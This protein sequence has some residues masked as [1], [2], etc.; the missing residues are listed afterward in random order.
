MKTQ[1]SFF[2]KIAGIC[3]SIT[4][5]ANFSCKKPSG[6]TNN[7]RNDKPRAEFTFTYSNSGFVPAKVIFSSTSSNAT[8]LNWRFGNGTISNQTAVEVTYNDPGTY[9][10]TLVASNQYGADSITKQVTIS[11]SKP[12][13]DFTFTTTNTEVLPVVVTTTNTTTGSNVTYK[14]TYGAVSSTDAN[15]V[16]NLSTGGI[17]NIKLVATNA[18]GSDSIVKSIRIS[19]YAQSYTT[20]DR[21]PTNLFA[22]DG[23][24]VMILSRNSNL[25]RSS[26][27]KWLRAMD[28]AYKY[29]SICTG[30]EPAYFTPTFINQR[31]TIA[32][33]AATCGAA[34]GYLGATGIEIQNTYFDIVYNRVNNTNSFEHFPFYEFG[35]NFWFYDTK[36]AY[37]ANDP[38]ATGYAVFMGFMAMRAAGVTGNSSATQENIIDIYLANTAYNWSNTLALGQSVPGTGTSGPDLFSSFCFRLRRDYGGDAFVEKLWK[39]AGQRPNALT[40]Q[41]AVDNFFLA[42]CGAANKNLTTVFQSWRWPLS[43]GAITAASQYP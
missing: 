32:D 19:P 36:L 27:F 3:I 10:V 17:Y 4:L 22:W 28:S 9:N 25:N 24:K 11:L 40:T 6:E 15:P 12:I 34:C 23:S 38:V 1:L 5:I 31:S 13:A 35:R 26:M 37:K 30:R 20:F 42:S 39:M 8:T 41:D 43:A 29:Y 21:V 7:S 33:V 2:F 14:W 18:G 16:F